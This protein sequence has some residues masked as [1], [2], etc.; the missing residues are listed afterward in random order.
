MIKFLH[1]YWFFALIIIPLYWYYEWVKLRFHRPR[2]VFP[3]VHRFK[4]MY[5][6]H[7]WQYW[8]PVIS[9][10]LLI[11]LLIMT[12]A[13]P[14]KVIE[15]RDQSIKG[16]DIIFSM[17]ISGS[18]LAVDFQP[19]NRLEASKKVAMNF[20]KNRESDRIGIVTFSEFAYT[21]APL[22]TS[23]Q[24]LNEILEQVEVD[25][26]N[27]GT[28]IGN[29]IATAVARLKDSKAK[30]KIIILIT[31][32]KNNSGEIDPFSA[33]DIAKTLGI[34]IYCIAVGSKGPVDYPFEDPIFGIRYQKV[35]I[36]MDMESLNKIAQVTGTHQAYQATNSVELQKIIR[37]IDKLEKSDIKQNKYY[38]YVELFQIFLMLALIMLILD[39]LFRTIFRNELP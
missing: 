3:L 29:G 38:E 16:I 4:S 19:V 12:L 13:R 31:D 26:E 8:V 2:I 30:S 10:S 28:A 11:F 33:A 6:H 1:P 21:Q 39:I 18:M 23:Y 9:K 34:K 7:H 15:Q 14:R 5:K 27:Q 25:K 35:I 32:G 20:I 36:D 24:F 22:T 37:E 17:D